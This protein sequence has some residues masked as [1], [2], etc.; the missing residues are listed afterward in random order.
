MPSIYFNIDNN[1]ISIS[2][3]EMK[4]GC[5]YHWPMSNCG[6]SSAFSGLKKQG[7][8]SKSKRDSD[9]LGFRE[10]YLFFKDL[11]IKI[12]TVWI[13]PTFSRLVRQH[14]ER[15]GLKFWNVVSRRDFFLASSS[16][17]SKSYIRISAIWDSRLSWGPNFKALPFRLE[18][19]VPNRIELC[20]L[21][22]VVENEWQ[23]WADLQWGMRRV[24][25]M[26]EKQQQL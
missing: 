11:W 8:W 16:S 21:W 3:G 12:E 20:R 24:G 17:S 14:R 5:T 7:F 23:R 15:N 18:N 6:F 22:N 10:R 19:C 25:D 9:S 13:F 2:S 26:D 1:E 4:F